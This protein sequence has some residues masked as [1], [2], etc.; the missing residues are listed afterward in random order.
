MI[1]RLYNE[2]ITFAL[3]VLLSLTLSACS[4]STIESSAETTHMEKVNYSSMFTEKE[5]KSLQNSN[6]QILIDVHATWCST[7]KKQSEIIEVYSKTNPELNILRVDF[8]KQKEW[9]KY[10]KATKSTFVIFKGDI[11]IGTLVAETN[12]DKISD[13]LSKVK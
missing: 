3:S 13:F 10:F 5:F 2:K 9:V 8:D 6:S 7:C 1:I 12:K 4:E 11:K